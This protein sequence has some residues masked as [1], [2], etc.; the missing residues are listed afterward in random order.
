[1][2]ARM[3]RPLLW[4]KTDDSTV[5]GFGQIDLAV[6]FISDYDQAP[7]IG[8]AVMVQRSY[9]QGFKRGETITDVDAG[10]TYKLEKLIKDDGF[11]RVIEITE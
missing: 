5:E 10:K 1:M 8:K 9:L 11:I 3:G 4:T 6:E 2:L 7:M